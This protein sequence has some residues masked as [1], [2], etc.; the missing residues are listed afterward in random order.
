M[1]DQ[2]QIPVIW[3]DGF[4][5]LATQVGS[6]AAWACRCGRI[7]LTPSSGHFGRPAAATLA[8]PTC[9][10]NWVIDAPGVNQAPTAV[11]QT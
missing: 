3:L 4:R 2:N 5:S 1:W 10:L 8:C 9:A 11:R 7:L 6:N